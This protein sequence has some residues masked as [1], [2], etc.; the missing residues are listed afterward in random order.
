M[1]SRTSQGEEEVYHLISYDDFI[2]TQITRFTKRICFW[3]EFTR[4][5]KPILLLGTVT[6]GRRFRPNAR[7]G[8]RYRDRKREG[9]SEVI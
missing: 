1:S 6:L 3:R 9:E 2:R 7:A 4:C 8:L 5:G